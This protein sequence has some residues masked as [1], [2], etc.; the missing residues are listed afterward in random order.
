[1]ESLRA[2]GLDVA[3]GVFGDYAEAGNLY[4]YFDQMAD[5]DDFYPNLVDSFTL[6]GE[7]YCAPGGHRD[8]RG[9]PRGSLVAVAQP[10][11]RQPALDHR[12]LGCGGRAR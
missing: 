2:R 4:P 8:E 1:M 7:A 3:T 5:S 9:P 10:L 6:D 12:P 11:G